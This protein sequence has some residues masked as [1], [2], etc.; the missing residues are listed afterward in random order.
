MRERLLA[1]LAP[2]TAGTLRKHLRDSGYALTPLVEGVRQDSPELLARTLNALAAEY[3]NGSREVRRA[4]REE[5]LQ[6][7]QHARWALA[8]RADPWREEAIGWMVLWLE[9]PGSFEPWVR[10]RLAVMGPDWPRRSG[11]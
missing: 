5:V 9:D 1:D 3:L 11:G 10:L 7:K 8:R 2:I 4:C 6:S